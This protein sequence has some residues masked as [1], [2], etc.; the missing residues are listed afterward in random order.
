VTIASRTASGFEVAIVGFSNI[1]AVSQATFRFTGKAGSNL[2]TTMVQVA[3]DSDFSAWY[4]SAASVQFGSQFRLVVP[5]TISGDIGALGSVS[6]SLT[7]T[8]G[9]STEAS[10]SF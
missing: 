9:T 6:V 4:G 1:R 5:F 8:E 3:V 7:S 10:A 2:A